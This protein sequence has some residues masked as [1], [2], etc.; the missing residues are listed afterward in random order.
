MEETS[1]TTA[2]APTA[3]EADRAARTS[4]RSFLGTAAGLTGVALAT[5]AWRPAGEPRTESPIRSYSAGHFALELD[6]NNE[7]FVRSV[8]GGAIRAEV[9][10]EEPRADYYVKKHIGPP[11]YEDFELDI[12]FAMSKDVYQ[13][14]NGA[15]TG[16]LL[17]KSGAIVAADYNMNAVS[18]REFQDALLVETAIPACDGGSKDPS[19]ITLRFAPELIEKKPAS[20]KLSGI[21]ATK[22][23]QKTWLPSNFRLDITKINTT[24]VSKIDAFTVKQTVTTDDVG[25]SRDYEREPGKVEF[26]NLVVS[27]AETGAADWENWFKDFVIAGRNEDANERPATLSF[28]SSNLQNVLA[29]IH[30][31]NMGIFRLEYAPAESNTDTIRRLK[32]H[33][34]YERAEFHIGP[35]ETGPGDPGACLTCTPP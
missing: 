18:R 21:T 34:Y 7:G 2:P 11:K 30:F 20:G 31:L 6:K 10:A 13:W 14:I 17:R 15:W 33:L 25:E 24:K 29:H 23:A 16:T 4:R 32:A 27:V 9:I 5:G 22:G 28:L 19:Y 26:G 3:E 35:I 12:D 8:D 1:T